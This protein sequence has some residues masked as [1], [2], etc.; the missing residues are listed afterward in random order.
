MSQEFFKT[1]T[2]STTVADIRI[3][4]KK[5]HNLLK[6]S[7]DTYCSMEMDSFG[8]FFFK[9]KTTICEGS[10]DPAWNEDFD[11]ELEG[12][13]TLRIL[14]FKKEAGPQGD[15]LLGR[16]AVEVRYEKQSFIH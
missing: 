1:S 2:L 4:M 10:R 6:L 5:N 15:R 11:L 14:C 7:T 3:F 9:A 16:G 12:S 13:Q 8:H